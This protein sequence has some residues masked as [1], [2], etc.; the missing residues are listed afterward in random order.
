MLTNI[1]N[2]IQ[3]RNLLFVV[4]LLLLIGTILYRKVPFLFFQ[5]DELLVFGLIIE[6]GLNI[7]TR[8]FASGETLH[9][10]PLL[11]LIDFSLFQIFSLNNVAYN[12]LGLFIHFINGLLI[13]LL[14]WLMAK[15]KAWAL[16]AAVVFLSSGTAAQLVMWP[17]VSIGMLSLTFA[18]VSWLYIV[19]SK[20]NNTKASIVV[21]IFLMMS[22]LVAE[23]SVGLLLFV[24]T[25]VFILFGFNIKSLLKFLLP[26]FL[27]ALAY[28]LLRIPSFFYLDDILKLGGSIQQSTPFLSQVVVY[29]QKL[30][31]LTIEYV[32][33]LIVP[34]SVLVIETMFLEK[35]FKVAGLNWLQLPASHL[36]V[37]TSI[38]ASG[39]VLFLSIF[40][41]RRRWI[42]NNHY[43]WTVIAFLLASAV[44][45]SFLPGQ[46]GDF[47]LFPPRYLYFGL[48]AISVWIG[49]IGGLIWCQKNK[50]FKIFYICAVVTM[51]FF[52]VYRNLEKSSQ[53]YEVGQLREY[54]L[55]DI[56]TNHSVLS[57]KVIFYT[58]SD[59]TFYGLSE[60]QR[61]LP[62]QS[63]FGQTLLV[64]YYQTEKF[65]KE[66]YK[67]NFLWDITAQG[68]KES[69]GRGFGYFRDFDELAGVIMN[70]NIPITSV[71][72]YS[73]NSVGQQLTD[74]SQEVWGRLESRLGNRELISQANFLVSTSE[75]GADASHMI[76]S[77][78]VTFWSSLVPYAKRGS[79]EVALN[80][81]YP[82]ASV[83]I[84]SYN[85][86]NQNEVG[87][88]VLL[89]SDGENW[90]Q[91]F[92]SDR[93]P[94]KEDGTVKLFF[95]PTKARYI[96]IE[97]IGYHEYAPWVIN[98]LNIYESLD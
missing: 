61:I 69:E 84:D 13:Y 1:K 72:A 82:L 70:Y 24:P 22:L 73:Y 50:I 42:N 86:K 29:F 40:I 48:A 14:V 41:Y 94:P 4:G 15:K 49:I 37:V 57:D 59:S 80:S 54:I 77:N 60:S 63:G 31:F 46:L 12:I 9:F 7:V 23:Y 34:R 26:S 90:V 71:V 11:N 64:W 91:V 97:Q 85:N 8:G 76:D 33:Q 98:E 36:W 95:R 53:L 55:K 19:K 92:Q 39:A 89:S 47:V 58:E 18:L 74:I 51:V 16:L 28:F 2:F 38:A 17:V 6:R 25:A 32:G 65:P 44:P 21:G 43:Y 75:N 78:K 96:R 66:F 27:V 45:F 35:I 88:R 93:Y 83:T 20:Q 30:I 3:K 81:I 68:Y 87:Y 79:V 52:G 67:D 10:I 56:K 62:F 5:Q